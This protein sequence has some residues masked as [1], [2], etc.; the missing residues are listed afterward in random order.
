MSVPDEPIKII[1]MPEFR[2]GV[3]T[4]YCDSPG[5]L[6][7]KRRDILRHLAD[8]MD[9]TQQR[10]LS[11]YREYNDFMLQDLTVHEAVPGHYLQ[12]AH[13]NRLEAPTLIRSIFYSGSFVEGWA[14]Y[15]EQ[16]MVEQGYGGA[17]FK[18]QQLKMLTRAV[19]N[20]ILDQKMHAAR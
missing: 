7:E 18:M 11:F 20:S 9:W 15:S 8:A 4:A 10:K 14:V 1:V 17:R 3:S 6:E 2:R 12:L 5:P 19:I 16:V 13:S